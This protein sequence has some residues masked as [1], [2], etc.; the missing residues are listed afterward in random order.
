M[1]G[2]NVTLG[3]GTVVT[4]RA[5]EKIEDI[6]TRLGGNVDNI[7]EGLDSNTN[8]VLDENELAGLKTKLAENDYQVELAPDGKTPKK[9]FNDAMQNMR[10]RYNNDTLK[11]YYM[12]GEADVWEI[13]RGDTLYDIAKE[14]LEKEGLPTD[15]KSINDRIAQLANLNGINDVNNI[16]V[17]T[18]IIYKLTEEGVQKVKEAE[19]NSAAAFGGTAPVNHGGGEG[20]NPVGGEGGSNPSGGVKPE[21]GEE[22]TTPPVLEG[23]ES[24][25]T[26]SPN[27]LN[28]GAGQYIDKD[29]NVLPDLNGDNKKK[30]DEGGSIM[31]YTSGDKVM[32]QTVWKED[33]GKLSSGVKLSAETPE[34][35]RELRTKFLETISK[36]KKAPADET[37]EAA[38]ARKAEN[39]AALKELV[40]ISGGNIQVI[41]NVAEKLR[42]DN[43]VDRKSDDYKA[44]VQ[45]ILLTKNADAV[46]ALLYDA[47]GNKK[48]AVLKY[49]KTAHEIVAGMYQE[50]RAKEKAGE[51]LSPEEIALKEVVAGYKN[52]GGY[53]I[54]ADE[55]NGIHEKLMN[56]NNMDGTIRYTV[57][58]EHDVQFS[59]KDPALL[60]EFVTK[61][62]A[63]DTDEKKTALFKEYMNT[64]DTE[65]ARSLALNVK[66]LCAA[67]EDIISLI[68]ANGMEV[69]DCLR[70]PED[71]IE[72][73]KEVVDAVVSRMKEIY[74]ADKGNLENAVFLDN[75]GWVDKTDMS[76]ED[77]NKIKEEILETYF[78]VTTDEQGNKTYTFNPSRRPT[79]EEM[80]G[81]AQ[82]SQGY[83]AMETALVNYLKLEDMGKGQYSEAI[84][85]GT[86]NSVVVKRFAEF[87]DGMSTKEEVIDFIDNKCTVYKDCNLPFDKILEKFPEDE[88]IKQRLYKNVSID[89]TISDA[90]RLTLAK[91][92]MK[93][94]GKGNVTFDKTKLPEGTDIR[95]F[96][97]YVL[98]GNCQKGDAKKYF[99]AV[100]K[101]LG[102]DDLETIAKYKAKNPDSV[103][104]R[105]G[106]LVKE[107]TSDNAFIQNVMKLDKSVI[108]FDV[109]T[110]IDAVQAKWDDKTKAAVFEGT[111]DNRVLFKDRAK[112]LEAAVNK[113]WITKVVTDEEGKDVVEDLYAIGDTLYKTRG[114]AYSGADKKMNTDDDRVFLIKLSKTGFDRGVAM[115]HE[116]DGAGSGDIA[117]MLRGKKDEGYENYVT[118]DNITGILTG[119]N[120][121]SPDEGIME[122]IANERRIS[123]GVKPGQALCN[124]IPKA[125]MR[126]AAALGLQDTQAYKALADFFKPD[127][128]FN[129]KQNDEAGE[130]YD[131]DT[132]KQLDG[133]IAAL[134]DEVLKK[135]GV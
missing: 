34:A 92:C 54:E 66:T 126:K 106:E 50:I 104:A 86:S 91:L 76:D 7:F 42:D 95:H 114:W 65:L 45:D 83:D 93:D 53:T 16:R 33:A 98:P 25:I 52:W 119:F 21:G 111:F 19:N 59:A 61:F 28:M 44:F 2:L 72:Y 67:D 26:V 134:L 8:G 116:L 23:R 36:V 77:K 102:K 99:D 73:S 80:L 97:E 35:L 62:E 85:R 15:F 89:S 39:L 88:G 18:K 70:K 79:H 130:K 31:K 107:N 13:K 75:L 113:H 14:T 110:G 9:A 118:P 128:K 51:M 122:Y 47:D 46:R 108:P 87:I 133:L 10:N 17:G 64:T 41:R 56:Y 68:N 55:E 103:K 1:A 30:F 29:G 84:E 96:I 3:D 58:L 43:Y 63:A 38:A 4:I 60:D 12:S 81:L 127:E 117:K 22:V 57:F 112:H 20:K 69:L 40:A 109:L 101:G 74:T 135:S 71:G 124:R 6:K 78:E 5:G 123:G 120:Q 27:G 129:F 125:L 121:M 37:E 24:T 11:G 100:L 82:C 132:A 94:D 105:I 90:N 115:F 48:S 32:Y 131:S 49:D